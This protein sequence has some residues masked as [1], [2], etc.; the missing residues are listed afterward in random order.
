MKTAIIF[1]KVLLL[2]GILLS[3]TKPATAQTG[4]QDK[5]TIIL[6]LNTMAG[7]LVYQANNPLP[8]FA[9]N[10]IV[11]YF[12]PSW[13]YVE[14][15][16]VAIYVDPE[17]GIPGEYRVDFNMQ[18]AVVVQQGTLCVLEWQTPGFRSEVQVILP[19]GAIFASTNLDDSAE[20]KAWQFPEPPENPIVVGAH[21]APVGF[22]VKWTAV[23]TGG[24]AFPF[25]GRAGTLTPPTDTPT[26]TRVADLQPQ[27]PTATPSMVP[28]T[29][30]TAIPQPTDTP[31]KVPTIHQPTKTPTSTQTAD[32]SSQTPTVKPTPQPVA[33]AMPTQIPDPQFQPP[34]EIPQPTET[35]TPQT[36]G[37]CSG[38]L[39][40]PGAICLLAM[41]TMIRKKTK[42]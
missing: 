5:Y 34:T 26:P 20:N 42:G 21:N 27:T 40:L 33:T 39:A 7:S 15:G 11:Y 14:K 16:E 28:T 31:T 9:H 18:S 3:Q 41:P 4:E 6:D 37:P 12:E 24:C 17:T 1:F 19:T 22:N 23:S 2:T 25:G 36:G 13:Q 8:S 30:P 29:Q 35:P 38:A 10:T 32:Q